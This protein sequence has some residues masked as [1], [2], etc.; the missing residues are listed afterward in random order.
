M[1]VR[2]KI[3]IYNNYRDII[4]ILI[5]MFN[6]DSRFAPSWWETALLCND[7][8]HWLGA[9]LESALHVGPDK[10]RICVIRPWFGHVEG[11][12]TCGFNLSRPGAHNATLFWCRLHYK[13]VYAYVI[14]VV[15]FFFSF[16]VR[17]AY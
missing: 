13:R 5:V 3:Y 16:K 2:G 8:S 9:N 6:A 17:Y 4:I 7:V 15:M 14:I 10:G 1:D 11:K 12:G